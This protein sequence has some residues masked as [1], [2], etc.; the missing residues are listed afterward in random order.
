MAKTMSRRWPCRCLK[1]RGLKRGEHS[2]PVHAQSKGDRV[3]HTGKIEEV[4][5]PAPEPG[6]D[7]AAPIE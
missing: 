4:E 6:E 3:P 5:V 7:I 2:L 1:A